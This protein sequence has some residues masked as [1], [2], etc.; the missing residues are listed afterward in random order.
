MSTHERD[1]SIL[2]H[3]I[4]YCDQ[5]DAAIRHFGDDELLFYSDA[6]FQNAVAIPYHLCPPSLPDLRISR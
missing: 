4:R 3:M 1:I 6:V 2:S 5:I